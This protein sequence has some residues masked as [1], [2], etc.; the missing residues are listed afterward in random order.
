M[1]RIL[2]VTT[3]ICVGL[4]ATSCVTT[5][6]Y[7]QK[8]QLDY[9]EFSV[10][11]HHAEGSFRETNGTFVFRL[12]SGDKSSNWAD[13][14]RRRDGE[15]HERIEIHQ[16]NPF[17]KGLYSFSYDIKFE[18]KRFSD[19]TTIFQLHHKSRT[20]YSIV[21][22]HGTPGFQQKIWVDGALSDMWRNINFTY[23][24][25]I[26]GKFYNMRWEFDIG[27]VGEVKFYLN[28]KY[29]DTYGVRWRNKGLDGYIKFGIYRMSSKYNPQP[30][31]THII[32]NIVLKKIK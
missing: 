9:G 19:D 20:D 6:S 16:R 30:A 12:R 5:E 31:A 10:Y 17:D 24:R 26:L 23:P 27:G 3:I 8:Y 7:P 28:G 18:G 32:T 21:G 11:G 22:E 4:L 25:I 14:R 15:W 29:I 13:V 1:I 2:S